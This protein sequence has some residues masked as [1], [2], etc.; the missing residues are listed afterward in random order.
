MTRRR[1][2]TALITGAGK[3]VGRVLALDLAQRGFAVAVHVNASRADGAAVAREI[4]AG[5]GKACTVQ[6]D[7]ADIHALEPMWRSAVGALGPIDV[8]INNASV[9]EDDRA[10]YV[11]PA[12]WDRQMAVNLRAPVFLTQMLARGLEDGVRGDVI[13]IID[14]RVLRLNPM[15][16]SYTLSKSALWTA[17]KTLAQGLAPAIRVNAIGPGPTLANTRQAAA[18]FAAQR[19]ATLLGEGSKPEEIAKA[20]AY[21]LDSEAVT[22]QMIAVDGGQHLVWRTPDVDGISK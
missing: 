7:L 8:L 17:T 4:E 1:H 18:D 11:A 15:F 9:F 14:Q 16:V 21:L 22:G 5:G 2:N 6:A 20:L 19:A 12:L 3:R 10:P 13:N